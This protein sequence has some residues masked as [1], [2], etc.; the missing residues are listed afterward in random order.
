MIII[1]PSLKGLLQ[2][3]NKLIF[4]KY[5]VLARHI[6]LYTHLLTKECYTEFLHEDKIYNI[7]ILKNYMFSLKLKVNK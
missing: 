6:V 5:L 2:E 1:M 4:V 3:A 7:Q